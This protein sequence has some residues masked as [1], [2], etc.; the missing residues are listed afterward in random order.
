VSTAQKI[1]ATVQTLPEEMALEVLDFAEYLQQKR[2]RQS[3]KSELLADLA[4]NLP[5]LPSF[6][7]DPVAIQKALR[8][9]WR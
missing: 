7:G 3:S 6:Q 2:R 5:D 4:E 8:D 1:L 9:E